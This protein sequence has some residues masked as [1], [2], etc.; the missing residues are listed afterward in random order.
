MKNVTFFILENNIKFAKQLNTIENLTC[1]LA[2]INWRLGN[3]TTIFCKTEKQAAKIDLALWNKNDSFIPHHLANQ[4]DNKKSFIEICWPK[5][6]YFYKSSENLLINLI[7][8]FSDYINSFKEIIDFVPQEQNLKQLARNRY[9][10][11]RQAGFYLKTSKIF[12]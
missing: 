6:I 8:K 2:E 1:N 11:Y 10:E 9:K 12:L 7:D 4:D 5:N 3:K